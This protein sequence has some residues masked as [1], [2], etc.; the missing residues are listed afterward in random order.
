M[1][2]GRNLTESINNSWPA[3]V[4]WFLYTHR[5]EV[6]P[7]RG[8]ARAFPRYTPN[9]LCWSGWIRWGSWKKQKSLL[10]IDVIYARLGVWH[11][12]ASESTAHIGVQNLSN[13]LTMRLLVNTWKIIEE[14]VGTKHNLMFLF[15]NKHFFLFFLS[16]ISL[17]MLIN[18]LCGFVIV[19]VKAGT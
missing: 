19:R 15:S 2:L 10:K 7:V 1:M 12:A 3:M 13:G 18:S 4:A 11:K 14:N 5:H 17:L 9:S 6:E 16:A 8:C